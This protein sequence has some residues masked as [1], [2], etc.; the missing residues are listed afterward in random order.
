MAGPSGRER[1]GRP[2]S[3]PEFSRLVD[4]SRLGRIEHRVS[5]AAKPEERAALARRFDLV[6]LAELAADLVLRRRGEGAGELVVEATGRWRAR[7]AQPSVVSLEPVWSTH[8]AEA[9][10]FFGS[11][12]RP[13]RDAALD[14]DEEC[15]WPEPIEDGRIDL[16][17]AVVQL[18]AVALEPYPRLPH[19]AGA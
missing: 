7:L 16:G 2:A 18:M 3:A 13:V 19:E 6:E 8:D 9:R 5:I 14:P 12:P 17:E 1:A 15:E 10:L 4:V 11:A